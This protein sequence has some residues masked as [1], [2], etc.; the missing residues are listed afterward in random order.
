MKKRVLGKYCYK[1]WIT[2]KLFTQQDTTKKNFQVL[3]SNDY[4]T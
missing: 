4:Y 2:F 1:F 3:S